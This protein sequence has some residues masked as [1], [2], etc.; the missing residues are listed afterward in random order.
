MLKIDCKDESYVFK[1]ISDNGRVNEI[2]Q[3]KLLQEH[4]PNLIPALYMF[5]ENAY[6]M[7]FID[8]ETF[9]T[10]NKNKKIEAIELCGEL[11]GKSWNKNEY[12]T[13]DISQKIEYVFKK[14]RETRKRFFSDDE[15]R[16]V[17]Y[18]D[19]TNVS[20]QPS[21]N[22]LNAANVIYNGEI[23][24]IDPA[25]KGYNDIARDIGRYCAST[26]F[27]E[28]DYFGN[29]KQF[30]LSIAEAFISGFDQ[31]TLK[32]AQYYIGESFLSFLNFQT[33]TTPK[34]ILKKLAIE[35]LTKERSIMKSLEKSL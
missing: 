34:S 20:T 9:F 15:L 14:Y 33:K 24:I 10:L 3:I 2:K 26:F 23:K 13:K 11:L 31:E 12:A 7:N 25:D 8:G 4:Y 18:Y 19:F 35:T 30:A 5:E 21:H 27:N 16:L 28:Y 32:R 1:K 6:L 17:N 22:D 29:N